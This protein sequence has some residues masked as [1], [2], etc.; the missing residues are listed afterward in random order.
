MRENTEIKIIKSEK[1]LEDVFH[2][3]MKI[4]KRFLKEEHVL[5]RVRMYL[6]GHGCNLEAFEKKVKKMYIDEN[7]CIGYDFR[8]ILHLLPFMG[9]A[10]YEL[11][12]DY[13]DNNISQ[14]SDKFIEYYS[15]KIS[16][17]K[18]IYKIEK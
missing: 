6:F 3:D 16:K 10:Y 8:D 2:K 18:I 17:N 1:E 9:E 4:F 11:G 13:W 15:N 12:H 7:F 5:F 14:I